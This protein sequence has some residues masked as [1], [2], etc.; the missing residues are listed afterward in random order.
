MGGWLNL[1][2]EKVNKFLACIQCYITICCYCH[3]ILIIFFKLQQFVEFKN[4]IITL[5]L[6][7]VIYLFMLQW[8]RDC[9]EDFAV[10][11]WQSCWRMWQRGTIQDINSRPSETPSMYWLLNWGQTL[12]RIIVA[13]VYY[14]LPSNVF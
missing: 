1:S 5:N 3:F 12:L 10:F 11:W 6:Y 8:W 4:V 13:S 7:L 14:M 9:Q 2:Y